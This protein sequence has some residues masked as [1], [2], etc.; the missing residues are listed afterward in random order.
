MIEVDLSGRVTVITG[1]SRG[2]GLGLA[3]AFRDT[4]TDLHIV[5]NDDSISGVVR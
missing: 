2:I 4:G 1:G 3:R 5:A